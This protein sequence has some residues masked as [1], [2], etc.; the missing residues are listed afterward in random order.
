MAEDIRSA[1]NKAQ[2]LEIGVNS[3]RNFKFAP[4]LRK[5]LWVLLIVTSLPIQLLSNAA[6]ILT[7]TSTAFQL[8]LVSEDFLQGGQWS[9]PGVAAGI[10]RDWYHSLDAYDNLVRTLQKDAPTWTRVES[11]ECRETYL[12][13]PNGLQYSRN[14]VVVVE[15]GPDPNA[16]GWTGANLWN[17]TVPSAYFN[18]NASSYDPNF[19]NSLWFVTPTCSTT[20]GMCDFYID[21]QM[22]PDFSAP[23]Q[24]QWLANKNFTT[25]YKAMTGQY[26]LVEPFTAPCKVELTNGFLVAVCLCVLIKSVVATWFLRMTKNTAP[27]KCL[28]DMV[29][30]LFEE[31]SDE[32]NTAGLSAYGQDWFR[33]TKPTRISNDP[34]YRQASW[35]GP[36]NAWSNVARRWYKAVPRVTWLS[37]YLFVGVILI[38]L[39]ILLQYSVRVAPLVTAGFG[40]NIGAT[41]IPEFAGRASSAIMGN[42]PLS[43]LTVF[44]FCFTALCSRLF[45]ASEWAAYSV[46]HHGDAKRLRVSEA[47]PPFQEEAYVLGVPLVWGLMFAGCNGGLHVL[48]GQSLFVVAAEGKSFSPRN[49]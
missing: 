10:G 21:S 36:P 9:V 17:D 48:V 8:A 46:L 19:V 31:H 14:L 26:C 4:P 20:D 27:I 28:G 2:W 44:Y 12:N 49:F 40:E 43:V 25:S 38:T 39:F 3:W 45:Q 15:S 47:R 23:W 32:I 16:A 29:Q 24:W 13:S 33:S 1:H 6:V 34:N 41:P 37:T 22:E 18:L 30:Y 35:I 7:H 11:H 5:A 42:L